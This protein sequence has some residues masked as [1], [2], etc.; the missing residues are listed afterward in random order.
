MTVDDFATPPPRFVPIGRKALAMAL[1]RI[2]DHDDPKSRLEQ[3]RTPG[4][5]AADMILEGAAE[6]D[7]VERTVVDL[8]CGT[9]VLAIGA[10]LAGAR[11]VVGID[12]DEGAV[13][14]ATREAARAGVD[15]RVSFHVADVASLEP[16]RVREWAGGPVDTV[17]MNP[18]FGAELSSRGR[19][20]DR[21]FLA[22]AFRLADRVLSFHLA[23]T[24]RFLVAFSRDAGFEAGTFGTV[25]FPVP[26]RHAHHRSEVKMVRV[27]VYRFARSSGPSGAT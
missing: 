9:G 26:A 12:I 18:P 22:L 19:G 11:R 5:I 10:A 21:V 1:S 17:V 4:D 25:S 15:D 23:E 13:A 3:V 27:G 7:I 2:Q 20:G 24:E 8:G 14:A 16:A 6:G